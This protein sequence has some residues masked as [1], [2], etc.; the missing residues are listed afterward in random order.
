MREI[1]IYNGQRQ[2]RGLKIREIDALEKQG[3]KISRWGIDIDALGTE[4]LAAKMFD[5]ILRAGTM[6]N[7]DFDFKEL[8]P[9]DERALFFGI[10]AETF[11]S[12][13]EKKTSSPSI[14]GTPTESA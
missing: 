9:A 13:A 1:E 7:G 8:T 12:L 10:L 5:E 14:A 2:V 4:E 6:C 3:Y 11:G